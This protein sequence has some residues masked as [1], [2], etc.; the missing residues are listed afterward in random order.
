[1]RASVCAIVAAIGVTAA[2]AFAQAD[3]NAAA[4]WKS[5]QSTCDAT[6]AKPAGELGHRIAQTATD[7][8]NG[9][10]GHRID[11]NGHLFHFGL[12]EAEHEEDDGGN[13]KVAL[14]RLGW[15]QVMKYWR[16]LF[17]NDAP[18]KLEVRG[19]S[20][21]STLTKEDEVAPLL[22]TSAGQLLRAL[23]AVSDP[24][25]R[26]VLREAALRAAV[27]DTSWSA[28]FIS[29]V[30]RQSGV[31][32]DILPM[33]IASISTTR[34]RPVRRSSHTNPMRGSIGPVRSPPCRG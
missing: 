4:F 7:E 12:T 8:F 19:Y 20:D 28:A 3:R 31:A 18:D 6:A 33:R 22:R 13:P 32:E 29:F 26:E 2:P 14:G 27:I 17:P 9:F 15:W 25:M 21:A 10:G 30:I 16:T 24:E 11:S 34:S 23:D 1:M 5:V